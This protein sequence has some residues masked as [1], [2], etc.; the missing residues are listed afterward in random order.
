MTKLGG[1]S[2]HILGRKNKKKLTKMFAANCLH[3]G[4]QPIAPIFVHHGTADDIVY[5][6]KN[7]EVALTNW[8]QLGGKAILRSY[9]WTF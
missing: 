5:Y 4:W 2:K 8:K 3:N 9:Y 7:V 1:M 6:D